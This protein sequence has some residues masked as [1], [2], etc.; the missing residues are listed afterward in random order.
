MRKRTRLLAGLALSSLP[1]ASS[2]AAPGD[3]ADGAA[4]P[5]ASSVRSFDGSR[6]RYRVTGGGPVV[7]LVHGWS[8]DSSYWDAQLPVLAAQYTVVTVDLAGHGAS[9]ATRSEWSMQ[10]FGR[11]VAAVVEALP[12]QPRVVLVG[13]SMGGPVIAEAAVILGERVAGLVGVDTF[14]GVGLPKPP[15]AET[16]A[17]IADLQADFPGVTRGMVAGRLFRPDSDPVLVQRVA[18][19]MASA[20]PAVGVPA[21]RALND[22]DGAPVMRRVRAPIVTINADYGPPAPEAVIRG[23]V[24]GFRAVVVPG[25]DH[26]LMMSDPA[27]VNPILEAEIRA[28]Q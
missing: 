14:K 20:P 26:F 7:V 24:P 3:A 10:A 25:S 9:E 23:F 27:R 13:H 12:G 18:D 19:D 2:L 15:A 5:A 22:W 8:C 16:E 21:L 17:R 11:D 28:L 4:A 1:A 6:I